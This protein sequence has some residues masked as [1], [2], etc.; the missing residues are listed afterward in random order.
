[1]SISENQV[2]AIP[3]TGNKLFRVLLEKS[4]DAVALLSRHRPSSIFSKGQSMCLHLS[5]RI[6]SSCLGIVNLWGKPFVK[7]NLSLKDREFMSFWTGSTHGM[8]NEMTGRR[9]GS[10][11]GR[12]FPFMTRLMT[13]PAH[14]SSRENEV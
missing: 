2:H 5:M 4:K 6:L 12:P 8:R 11:R 14:T 1:M 7:H 9:Q 10:L 3:P 13:L